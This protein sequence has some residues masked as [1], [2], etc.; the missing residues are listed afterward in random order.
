MKTNFAHINNT[1]SNNSTINSWNSTS[2]HSFDVKANDKSV[3]KQLN[4][5]FYK[6]KE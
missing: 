5:E 4:K 2:V 6:K 3:L 1:F